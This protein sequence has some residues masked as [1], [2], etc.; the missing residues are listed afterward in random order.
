PVLRAFTAP[1]GRRY[2]AGWIGAGEIHV[3]SPKL[4]ARRASK[5]PGSR[6]M[7]MLVPAALYARL[8]VAAANK[9]WAPP[10]TPASTLRYLRWAWLVEGAAQWLSGRAAH[11][12]PAIRRRLH[13]GAKPDFPPKLRDAALLGGSVIDLLAR[14][15]G[16]DAVARL[17][18]LDA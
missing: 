17:V 12:G 11:A 8:A 13:E 10:F 16:A 14:E 5:V 3:L 4:L 9:R 15:V 1:A 18:L 2:L 7:V 6:E